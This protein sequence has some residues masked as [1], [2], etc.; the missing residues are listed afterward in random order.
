MTKIPQKSS[1]T[2]LHI[3]NSNSSEKVTFL[4]LGLLCTALVIIGIFTIFDRAKAETIGWIHNDI[5]TQDKNEDKDKT[6]RISYEELVNKKTSTLQIYYY[7]RNENVLILDF[8]TLH[9]QGLMFNRV[10]A[11]VEGLGASKT[12]L[13]NDQELLDFIKNKLLTFE[14]FAFGNDFGIKNIVIFFNLANQTSAILNE[15]EI[16]LKDILLKHNFMLI[17]DDSRLK[18]T[19]IDKA[20]VSITQLQPD[21]PSSKINELIDIDMRRTVLMHELSH[22]EFFTNKAYRD[23]CTDF[24]RN[25]ML[26]HE[27]ST[28]RNM[29]LENSYDIKIEEV[30]IN[31]MQAYLMNTHDRRLFNATWL[32]MTEDELYGM[33]E[34]FLSGNPPTN[35]YIERTT[36][37]KTTKKSIRSH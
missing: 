31:E 4:P 28:F 14:T 20:V 9:Q 26:K 2:C 25:K 29:L 5:K 37:A 23:Y 35:L 8:P 17:G 12:K 11:F 15:E 22:G 10:L 13:L 30:C 6:S 1:L 27:K 34:K 32:E 19:P 21:D 33:Q 18:T 3:G 36:P 24:W 16:K 7:A